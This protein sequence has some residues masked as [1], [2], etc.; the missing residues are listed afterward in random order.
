MFA[1][2]GTLDKFRGDGVL[3][4]FGAPVAH[5]DDPARAVRCALDL[6][7]EI[8]KITVAT[9]PELRLHVGIGINTGHVI[10]GTIGSP[11]RMDYTVIGNEV[12]VAAR[13]EAN[14]GPGQTL[15]T[16]RTYEHVKDLVDARE[17]G[18]LRVKGSSHAVTAFDVLGL[19]IGAT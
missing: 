4:V 6:Q 5:D 12:N 9:F 13:F 19:K 15:I 18:A 3:A 2:G 1:Y 10:A 17:L 16:G 14:A 7:A 8:K 11:R